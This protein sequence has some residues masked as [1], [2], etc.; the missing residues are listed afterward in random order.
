MYASNYSNLSEQHLTACSSHS[1]DVLSE[2]MDYNLNMTYH[3]ISSSFGYDL[4]TH[5]NLKHNMI[6]ISYHIKRIYDL[7]TH[8]ISQ[9]KI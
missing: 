4:L 2:Y 9:T 1:S 5:M 8:I 3:L 7:S 6:I